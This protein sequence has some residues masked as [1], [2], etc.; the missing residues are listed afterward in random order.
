M[1]ALE[2]MFAVLMSC[3]LPAE[4]FV[5]MQTINVR[6]I[7]GLQIPEIKEGETAS[8]SL[9]VPGAEFIFEENMVH[10]KSKNSPF[11]GKQLKGKV[12]GIINKSNIQ[13]NY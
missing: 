7:F 6:N 10:S 2:T 3:G 4:D 5:K 9:F 8:L 12:I 11:I 13:L 1:I